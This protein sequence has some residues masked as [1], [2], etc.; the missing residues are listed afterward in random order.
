[1]TVHERAMPHFVDSRARRTA[2]RAALIVW[3]TAVLAWFSV[4]IRACHL[5][6]LLEAQERS[7]GTMIPERVLVEGVS[8]SIEDYVNQVGPSLDKT[9]AAVKRVRLRIELLATKR[10]ASAKNTIFEPPPAPPAPP[11]PSESITASQRTND[12]E[13]D[14]A[15][16]AP[17]D[18]TPRAG[19]LERD[20]F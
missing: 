13:L 20:E 10:K 1:M 4:S 18:V 8:R 17:G 3:A 11:S 2:K 19:M 5:G 14:A 7:L 16:E 9:G 12:N 15:S 6:T